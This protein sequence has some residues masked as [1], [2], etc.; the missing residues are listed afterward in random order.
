MLYTGRYS[1]LA[2][3][4]K[5]Q[6]L[7]GG[8]LALVLIGVLFMFM[9]GMNGSQNQV[10]DTATT[11]ETPYAANTPQTPSSM[12]TLADLVAKGGSSS[13]TVSTNGT[14]AS[15]GTVFVSNGKV[16]GDFTSNT[17]AGVME[18]HMISDGTYVYVWSSA[19]KTGIKMKAQ[20]PT[21]STS[22]PATSNDSTQNPYSQTYQYSCTPWAE[23]DTKFTLPAG[24]TFNDM[25][26]MMMQ[27]KPTGAT[28]AGSA[29][30]PNCAIC[31]QV[32]A[33]A[34]AQCLAALNCK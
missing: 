34:K 23:D 10:S 3:V 2:I 13:C 9:T 22:T 29:P 6:I 24:M 21:S 33:A 14:I 27:A 16:R 25:S 26:A 5:S 31:D 1:K 15:Q 19:M 8:A 28:S 30:T 12:G 11:T 4:M 7:I 32:P 18:S 20:K 17:P